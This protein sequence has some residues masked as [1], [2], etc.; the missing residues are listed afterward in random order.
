MTSAQLNQSSSFNYS[1]STVNSLRF[2]IILQTNNP[3]VTPQTTD[4]LINYTLPGYQLNVTNQYTIKIKS[5]SV[6]SFTPPNDGITRQSYIYITDGSS[7]GTTQTTNIV[8]T[9]IV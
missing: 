6:V 2:A 1:N 5:L 3:F 8:Y 4:F 7:S 9:E